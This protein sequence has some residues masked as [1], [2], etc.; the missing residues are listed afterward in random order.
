MFVRYEQVNYG[1]N[2]EVI[3]GEYYK[4]LMKY[5]EKFK[6]DWKQFNEILGKLSKTCKNSGKN[7][8]N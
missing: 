4:I 1:E 5:L 7:E 6:E 3:C 8:K 2:F